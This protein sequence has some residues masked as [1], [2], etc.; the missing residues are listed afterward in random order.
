MPVERHITIDSCPIY[1]RTQGTAAPT[2]VF[3]AGGGEDSS[4]WRAVEP[5]TSAYAA[6]IVYDRR[7]TGRSGAADAP[8]SF[9]DL[10]DD[11]EALIDSCAHSHPCCL[12][13]TL[14]VVCSCVSLRCVGLLTCSA[15]S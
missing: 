2:V 13:V 7:G 10:V 5:A 14:W 4:S 15:W 1:V 6:T 12:S 8:R 3:E 11:L 9:A